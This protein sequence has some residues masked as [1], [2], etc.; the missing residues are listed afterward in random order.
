MVYD[1][2]IISF[3]IG[4]L[5]GGNLKG[6]ADLKLKFGWI[7]PILLAI[8]FAIYFTQGHIGFIASI[9]NYIFIFV[10]IIGLFFLWMNRS[11][12]GIPLIFIGVLL[13]FVVMLVNG[14]RMPVS[15][16]AAATLDP[17]YVE[18]IKN[19]L[20]A[21]HSLLTGETHLAFLGDIIPLTPPYP[22]EQVI[23]IGDI[24]MNIGVYF[25]IQQIMLNTASQ[26]AKN[27]ASELK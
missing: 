1:G 5:R 12:R 9:S 18:A 17:I 3:I 22:R 19:G 8:Q 24:I 6:I 20:Y 7:F 4:L 27:V 16:E 2:I 23:S 10:Y 26:K 14:G 11:Y 25:F 13:N 21:K 15:L